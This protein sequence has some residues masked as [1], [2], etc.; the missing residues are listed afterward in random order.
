MRLYIVLLILLFVGISYTLTTF[1]IPN[2]VSY[3]EREKF[4]EEIYYNQGDIP[5]YCFYNNSGY[6]LFSLQ[7]Y[8]PTSKLSTENNFECGLYVNDT[9]YFAPLSG[10]VNYNPSYNSTYSSLECGFSL[11]PFN[12]YCSPYNTYNFTFL[13]NGTAEDVKIS[14]PEYSRER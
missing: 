10:F 7:L 8:I 12:I 14:P 6:C 5:D 2:Y 4:Y 9:Y 3:H 1:V 13:F 11:S